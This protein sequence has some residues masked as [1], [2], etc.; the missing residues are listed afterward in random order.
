MDKSKYF[1][2]QSVFGQL[3]SLIDPTIISETVKEYQSDYRIK[4]FDTSDHLISMLFSTFAQCTSL[5]EVSGSMLGLKGK[6]KHFQ[7]KHIPFRST[8]SDANKRRSHQVFEKI[9][10][11]LYKRHR[12][13]ISDSR[14]EYDWEKRV[15]I[16]DSTTISLFK[17]ILQCVGREPASGKRK[18]GIK[19]HA[20]I[21][22][23]EQVPK[24]IWFSSASTHDKNFLNQ[25]NL[26]KGKIAV[27]DK[28]YNDYN[29]F[30]SFTTNGIF[31]VTRIKSNA[32]YVPVEEN[33]I[34]DYLDSAVLKDE[35]IEVE[36]KQEGKVAKTLRLRRIAYWDDENKRCFEFLTNFEGINAGHIAL[37]YKKRWQ[38]E[39]LFKQLKQNF[40]LKYFL[41][42]NENAIKIQIWCT[43]IVNL[44]LTVIKKQLKRKWS[45]SN[46]ASFC[47]LHLFNYLHLLRFLENPEKDWL[48]EEQLQMK[49]AFNSG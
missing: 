38:I 5:R 16:V 14:K 44:L 12:H 19:V 43:L 39:L 2:G 13:I 28:G 27:F 49:F 36:V 11:S 41:G 32:S 4:K 31:F 35:W 45:F 7:L 26:A 29:T 15:E 42:D 9:Y 24:L 47:R 22:L 6:T 25:L 48:K 20:Q 18:G 33:D 34:P 8:L 21:N 10:Y 46:L 37:I 3:I 30:D 1:F 23:Q 17:D 40:P